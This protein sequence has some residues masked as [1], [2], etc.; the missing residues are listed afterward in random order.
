[1]R[2]RRLLFTF[3]GVLFGQG[4]P[5]QVAHVLA[6]F[7][8][9]AVAGNELLIDAAGIF[10]LFEYIVIILFLRLPVA[11][12]AI[13]TNQQRA[14]F[15]VDDKHQFAAGRTFDPA[16]VIRFVYALIIFYILDHF[17]RICADALHKSR[18]IA[19]APG[20]SVEPFFPLGGQ[21]RGFQT[22]RHQFDKLGAFGGGDK[23]LAVSFYIIGI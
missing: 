21:F 4:F 10:T 3:P 11:A 17:N 1:M 16:H 20:H 9:I 2:W 8:F 18:F 22:S 5:E 14:F 19:F 6:Y 13:R 23:F 12:G 7:L 15:A